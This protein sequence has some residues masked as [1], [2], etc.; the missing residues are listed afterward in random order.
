MKEAFESIPELFYDFIAIFM[1]GFVAM[2]L[3]YIS[4]AM[5]QKFSYIVS[6][7]TLIDKSLVLII[8]SYIF[9]Q[10]I[11][12]LSDIVIRRP[13]WLLFGDPEKNLLGNSAPLI[14][15]IPGSYDSKHITTLK[16][17]IESVITESMIY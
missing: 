15:A 13:V 5:Q 3:I 14:K 12:M 16:S 2:E 9:G 6:T 17:E 1:P 10:A 11:T 4:P 8:G 7:Q